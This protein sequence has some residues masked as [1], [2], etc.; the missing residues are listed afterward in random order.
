MPKLQRR[1]CPQ[2]YR[3]CR[4][5]RFVLTFDAFDEKVQETENMKKELELLKQQQKS[6]EERNVRTLK[7]IGMYRAGK[8]DTI[9]FE[10][11]LPEE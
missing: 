1:K 8:T 5:C 4:K 11:K 2:S 10:G 9:L 6:Y 7:N 3:F